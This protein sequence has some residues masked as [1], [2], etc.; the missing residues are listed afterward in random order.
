MP[1]VFYLSRDAIEVNYAHCIKILLT[2][3]PLW[4][5]IVESTFAIRQNV[6]TSS[7]VEAEFTNIKCRAFNGQ[8]PMKVDKFILQHVKY[9]RGKLILASKNI[10]DVRCEKDICSAS[11][12]NEGI[13]IYSI[14]TPIKTKLDNNMKTLLNYIRFF[15]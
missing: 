13:Y 8:L 5:G 14:L 10:G 12:Q 1:L 9:L 6:Y 3:L 15:Y 11:V 4:T 7:S 2:H